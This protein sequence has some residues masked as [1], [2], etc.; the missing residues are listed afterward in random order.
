MSERKIIEVVILQ[1]M[2]DQYHFFHD[3]TFDDVILDLETLKDKFIGRDVRFRVESYGHEGAVEIGLVERRLETDEE[4]ESRVRQ[5][6]L[7]AE[8]R[9]LKQK[10]IDAAERTEYARL[11]KKFEKKS[12]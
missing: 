1:S 5:E 9:T 4:Y 3:K 10:K 8:K 12:K 2:I 11:K 6:T 7:E